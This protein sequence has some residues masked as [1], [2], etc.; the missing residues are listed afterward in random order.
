MIPAAL[1]PMHED[2]SINEEAIGVMVERFIEAGMHGIFM[3]GTNG[4]FFS[5]TQEEKVAVASAAVKAANGRLPVIV[6]TGG[7]S[8]RE[9]V[10]LT[11]SMEEI[12]A[13]AVSVITPYFVALTQA[14]LIQHYRTVAA[15]TSL[16]ILL[17]NM[18][19]RTNLN[20]EPATVAILAEI[21]N[22]VGIKDSSGSFDNL[23]SY[24][25]AT[26]EHFAVLSGSDAL[27]YEAL[28]HGCDGAIAATANVCPELVLSIYSCQ[29]EGDHQGA[30]EAQRLLLP[31]REASLMGSTPAVYKAA[32]QHLGIAV[33]PPRSPVSPISSENLCKLTNLLALYTQK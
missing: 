1:T 22:I 26:P 32:L 8:T 31:L 2:Q 23:M 27:I 33:G 28:Q 24:R 10:E 25:R 15:S 21:P 19:S 14:E 20:L 9:V 3:L 30:Q 11:R 16:P 29:R 18:P 4:E 5:L 12:G 13:A 17:Y 6:G 7:V